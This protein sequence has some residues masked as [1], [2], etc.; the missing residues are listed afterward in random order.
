[1]DP[2]KLRLAEEALVFAGT[3]VGMG[4]LTGIVTSWL[5]WRTPKRIES[6]EIVRRLDEISERLGRLDNAMDTVAVEVERISEAQRFTS[7]LLA[8]RPSTPALPER[9]RTGSTTPH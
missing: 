9:S 1:M 4:C 7:K 2:F 6:P 3:V 5:K 8:E